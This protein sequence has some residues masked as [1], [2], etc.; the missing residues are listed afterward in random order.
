MSR[1]WRV[2]LGI[3]L[4]VAAGLAGVRVTLPGRGLPAAPFRADVLPRAPREGQ[5]ASVRIERSRAVAAAPS[6]IYIVGI[7]KWPS[8]WTYLTPGGRWVDRSTPYRLALAPAGLDPVTA[9]WRETGPAG[10]MTVVVVFVT[11][12]EEIGNRRTWLFQPLV[13][14]VRV[15]GAT[16][17]THA[18]LVLGAL[19]VATLG[20]VLLVQRSRPR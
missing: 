3:G 14:T 19:G 10:E 17:P 2:W 18:P 5:E 7:R 15:R 20:A 16:S 11:P 8:R 12:G 6:D 1:S 13:Q 4:V 9:A